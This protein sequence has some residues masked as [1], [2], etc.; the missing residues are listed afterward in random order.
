MAI[1]IGLTCAIADP[2]D[3]EIRKAVAT[4]DLLMGRDE[5][6]MRFLAHSRA[7]WKEG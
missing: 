1:A 3:V 4:S 6:A 2:L 7:G 5:Y